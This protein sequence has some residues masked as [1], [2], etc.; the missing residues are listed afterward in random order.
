[1]RSTTKIVMAAKH[2][3]DRND[4]QPHI[5]E[6]TV[7]D[8]ITNLLEYLGKRS[9]ATRFDLVIC[10]NIQDAQAALI[11]RQSGGIEAEKLDS[12]LNTLKNLMD[13]Q[14]ESAPQDGSIDAM[15]Q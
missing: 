13:A 8:C 5:W 14:E 1:M 12:V 10:R 7:I 4:S 3:G 15:D 6:G 9:M 2:V 11:G